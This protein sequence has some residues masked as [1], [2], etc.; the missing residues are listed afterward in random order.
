MKKQ[1]ICTFWG[2]VRMN[3]VIFPDIPNCEISFPDEG[4]LTPVVQQALS[5][6]LLELELNGEQI[7]PA[8]DVKVLLDQYPGSSLVSFTVYLATLRDAKEHKSIR[9]NVTIDKWLADAADEQGINFSQVLQEG[10]R[11]VLGLEESQPFK[12]L[13]LGTMR[14]KT[15]KTVNEVSLETRIPVRQLE[16]LED[17]RRRINE[18]E[19]TLIAKAFGCSESELIGAPSPYHPLD[20]ESMTDAI[21]KYGS[22]DG[23][24]GSSN[25]RLE[26]FIS[27]MN[28]IWKWFCQSEEGKHY[29]G[30][31]K[32]LDPQEYVTRFKKHMLRSIMYDIRHGAWYNTNNFPF[33][34]FGFNSPSTCWVELY[35]QD[36]V[37]DDLFTVVLENVSGTSV[38]NAC[39]YYIP[40]IVKQ[41]LEHKQISILEQDKRKSG[42]KY[43]N[44][45][46]LERIWN[47]G[48][49]EYT[50]I[51]IRK[52]G[53]PEWSSGSLP[54]AEIRDR[55]E[56]RSYRRIIRAQDLPKP[57]I[58][59]KGDDRCQNDKTGSC[60][61][62]DNVV[63]DYL[64]GCK[65][66]RDIARTWKARE[67]LLTKLSDNEI[68][69]MVPHNFAKE[70]PDLYRYIKQN[71]A[72]DSEEQAEGL[73]Y[74]IQ[75]YGAYRSRQAS[76]IHV[77]EEGY[78]DGRHRTKIAQILDMT[79]P[80]I[81]HTTDRMNL[82]LIE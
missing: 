26:V 40:A 72:E 22:F 73:V 41:I 7:P 82:E 1:N 77:S 29:L 9:K 28:D 70:Y 24:Y 10:I 18:K 78:Q 59:G 35:D 81:W 3:S 37:T 46:F 39:E 69:K 80:V 16:G 56:S 61:V 17:G 74:W 25:F 12:V 13:D 34:I 2:I 36:E 52:D 65:K 5:E 49:E 4:D 67:W 58:K 57:F 33:T 42:F 54:L 8:T 63:P 75:E 48:K 51:R 50:H 53:S 31:G 76:P 38:T 44:I 11:R 14:R 79:I 19:I 68:R 64:N 62:V 27:L 60:S 30:H 6:R 66:C 45:R 21:R 43:P 23:A 71:F 15:G 55:E 47:F 20:V 32:S